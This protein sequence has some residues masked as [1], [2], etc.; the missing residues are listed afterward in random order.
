VSLVVPVND[1]VPIHHVVDRYM[2]KKT[3]GYLRANGKGDLLTP[4]GDGLGTWGIMELD[5]V[6]QLV[7]SYTPNEE[8]IMWMDD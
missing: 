6:V 2:R 8:M 7:V 1:F 3:Q 5:G 4:S